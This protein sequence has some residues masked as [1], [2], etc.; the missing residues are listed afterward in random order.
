MPTKDIIQIIE[1][2]TGSLLKVSFQTFDEDRVEIWIE[3][4]KCDT[5]C[6]E[7]QAIK[8]ESLETLEKS[9]YDFTE[10][11]S[12]VFKAVDDINSGAPPRSHWF[13]NC[14][15]HITAAREEDKNSLR[16]VINFQDIFLGET[17]SP[18]YIVCFN[19]TLF[20]S[21]NTFDVLVSVLLQN[22]G[23]LR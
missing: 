7:E 15:Y 5:R 23:V 13:G 16:V 18:E 1:D 6:W 19:E 8:L 22:Q 11:S 9:V 12:R 14:C 4:R 17:D 3:T 21:K 10:A 20:R 2:P